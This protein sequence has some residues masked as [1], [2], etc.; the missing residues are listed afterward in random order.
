MYTAAWLYAALIPGE[1]ASAAV[2]LYP[3]LPIQRFPGYSEKK[4]DFIAFLEK[5]AKPSLNTRI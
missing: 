4:I 3:A 1:R 5:N 2:S